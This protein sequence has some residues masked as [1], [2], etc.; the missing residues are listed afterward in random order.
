MKYRKICFLL[1]LFSLLCGCSKAEVPE[2]PYR[3]KQQTVERYRE[4]GVQLTRSDYTYDEHNHVTEVQTYLDDVWHSTRQLT[5]DEYGN[6]VRT[7]QIYDEGT[8]SIVE[9]VLT[10]D[11]QHRVIRSEGTSDDGRQTLT[12]YSY[13]KDGQTTKLYIYRYEVMEGMDINSF[14]DYTYDRKGN[15]VRQDVRWE[16]NSNNNGYTLCTYEKDRLVRDETY[17]GEELD[18]YTDYTYDETGLI[19]TAIA[20]EA[21]GSPHTKH[22]TTFD[23]FGNKLEVIAYAYYHDL[24]VTG[25]TD[26]EPDSR[27]TYVYE[28]KEE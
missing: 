5:Y 16:P 20:Y 12:E 23:E 26:E 4:E 6:V 3:L 22:I 14:T 10:L 15:L 13:N 7:R 8:E 18:S 19:Q 24:M 25:E 11:E 2:N 27:T 21:D 28:L 17:L 9:H 1:A